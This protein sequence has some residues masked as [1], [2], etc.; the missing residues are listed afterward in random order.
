MLDGFPRTRAQA[1]ALGAFAALDA[2]INIYVPD[3]KLVHRICGRRV[4]SQ[5]SANY[6]ESMLENQKICPKCGAA[7]F[8]R[9]DDREKIVKQRL[10][11]YKDK[12]QPLIDYYTEKGILHDVV[13]WGGIDTITQTI[14][15][16]LDKL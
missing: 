16:V 10:S 13:G 12:T 3:D 6:H 9:D 8:I 11:V 7:L 2:V 15:S 4:C 1:E 5:C 14:I